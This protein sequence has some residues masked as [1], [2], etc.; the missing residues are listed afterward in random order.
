MSVS[1]LPGTCELMLGFDERIFF[2]ELDVTGIRLD[3]IELRAGK[4]AGGAEP[5]E[6]MRL[7]KLLRRRAQRSPSTQK[8][9]RPEIHI[10]SGK[11]RF[12]NNLFNISI[13]EFE[14]RIGADGQSV[15]EIDGYDVKREDQ[16]LVRGQAAEIQYSTE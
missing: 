14:G 12:D 8:S 9:S 5:S 16:S 15:L 11:I 3:G 2:G 4:K 1:T 13:N 10:S 7:M 6:W